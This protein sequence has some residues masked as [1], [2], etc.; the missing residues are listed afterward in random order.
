M[1]VGK[2]S[3]VRGLFHRVYNQFETITL[4]HSYD[5][6]GSIRFYT[7][8]KTLTKELIATSEISGDRK[9][10]RLSPGAS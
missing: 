6:S 3:D 4:N 2:W 9:I 7:P 1:L 5:G 8:D 10:V